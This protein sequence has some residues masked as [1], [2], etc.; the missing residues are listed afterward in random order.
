MNQ[1]QNGGGLVYTDDSNYRY[2]ELIYAPYPEGRVSEHYGPGDAWRTSPTHRMQYLLATNSST[3]SS[4][5]YYRG[6]SITWSG[7]TS[8]TLSRQSAPSA[9]TMRVEETKDEDGQR[10]TSGRRYS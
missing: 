10:T 1:I 6:F 9:N 3:T 4:A 2:E 8:L 5:Y 7:N